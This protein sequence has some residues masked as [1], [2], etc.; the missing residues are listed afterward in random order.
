MTDQKKRPVARAI[1]YFVYLIFI[2]ILQSMIMSRYPIFGAKPLILPLV[3]VSAAL[4]YG[5]VTGGVVGLFAGM[6]TDMSFN[7]P[8]IVF[9]LA[10]TFVGLAVGYMAETVLFR[11]LPA[12]LLTALLALVFCA[13]V[14]AARLLFISGAPGAL[15]FELSLRQLASSALFALPIY[16]ITKGFSRIV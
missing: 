10:L 12:F 5:R 7:E 8:T 14:Q 16:F 15:L 1:I 13:F 4:F 11:G 2:F 3:A 6:L 9:T